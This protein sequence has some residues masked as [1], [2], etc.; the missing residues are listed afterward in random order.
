M[1][2]LSWASD[3]REWMETELQ[4][5]A[6]LLREP[7]WAVRTAIPGVLTCEAHHVSSGRAFAWSAHTARGEIIHRHSPPPGRPRSRTGW[8]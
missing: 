2:D 8:P 6:A 1:T 5:H 3:L 7:I 4:D